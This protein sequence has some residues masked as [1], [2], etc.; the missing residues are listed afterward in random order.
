MRPLHFAFWIFTL[1]LASCASNPTNDL[2]RLHAGMDKDKV[3]E[4]AGNPKFTFRETTKDHWVY[5][6][7]KDNQEWQREV[8][9]DDGIVTRISKPLGK[10]DWTK[11]LEKAESMEEFEKKARAHQKKAGQFKSIDGQPDNAEGH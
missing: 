3:L 5:I 2:E 9:F 8:I 7:F 11:D 6:Y 4:V 1:S 10:Q